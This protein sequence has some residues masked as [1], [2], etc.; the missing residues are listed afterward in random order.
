MPH[1]HSATLPSPDWD[2]PL[3]G[4]LSLEGTK[5]IGEQLLEDILSTGNFGQHDNRIKPRPKG[6]WAG[7]WYT[8]CRATRRCNELRQ[9]AP[10]EALWY[11][12]TLIGDDS[13]TNKPIKRSK[14]QE[15]KDKEI[16]NP[17]N[18]RNE[19]ATEGQKVKRT[20]VKNLGIFERYLPNNADVSC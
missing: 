6:Y 3:T 1:K 14:R 5:Q 15:S 10:Y 12:V 13:Y 7:K 18:K 4:F 9:F 19:K 16:K 8:F 2:C 11:P 20:D 17:E